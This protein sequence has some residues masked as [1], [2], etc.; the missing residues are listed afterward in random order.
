MS[1][2]IPMDDDGV[3]V[4]R[5]RIVKVNT[6]LT[7]PFMDKAKIPLSFTYSNDPNNLTK[8]KYVTGQIGVS[9]DFG[10]IWDVFK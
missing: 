4:D 10:A 6:T 1:G 7:L 2:L 5:K 3:P 8:E 9:Y